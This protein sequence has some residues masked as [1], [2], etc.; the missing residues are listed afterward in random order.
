MTTQTT[1]HATPGPSSKDREAWLAARSHG[2]TATE[3]R[4]AAKGSSTDR[5]K[6]ITAKLTGDHK[7]LTGNK[8]INRGNVREPIIAEWIQ[9][10]YGINPSDVVYAHA[11]DPRHLATPDGYTIDP[12]TQ[13]VLVSEIKTSKHDLSP[14]EFGTTVENPVVTPGLAISLNGTPGAPYFWTT[15]YYDQ[16]Q[17]QMHVLDADRMLFVY[18][19]HDDNW[20]DPEA[21]REPVAVWIQRDNRRIDQLVQIANKLLTEIEAA[22][23][24]DLPQ[25]VGT[26]P[27]EIA[28]EVHQ[29]LEYRNTESIA[30]TAKESVWAKI[31][32]Y[33][34]TK[35]PDSPNAYES[36]EAKVAW[37]NTAKGERITY[38][39]QDDATPAKVKTL[40]TRRAAVA[41]AEERITKAQEATVK[42]QKA[43]D[44]ADKNL[45]KAL[46]PWA[47]IVPNPPTMK[48]TITANR[49]SKES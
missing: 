26:I 10:R 8:F 15:G 25:T 24:S 21:L 1:H 19:Q 44:V 2:I 18:E 35:D 7:D 3:V 31:G 40:I 36:A 11:G 13:E 45:A 47:E 16:M 37:T 30:K 28:D 48:L 43:K 9:R 23:V 14:F 20:P 39:D 46:E 49:T 12:M 17:W 27:L 22:R 5:R 33:F 38:R 34:R 41:R 29:L 4:E 32:D 42:A 6:I